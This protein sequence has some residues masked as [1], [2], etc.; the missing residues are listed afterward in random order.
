MSQSTHPPSDLFTARA[1]FV[2]FIKEEDADREPWARYS[3]K[4]HWNGAEGGFGDHRVQGRWKDFLAGWEA[5]K[6]NQ[7]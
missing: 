3:L 2:R 7:S 1:A 4:Q 5:A 6:G